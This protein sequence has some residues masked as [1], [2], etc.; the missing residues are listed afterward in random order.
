MTHA[1]D[2]AG[3]LETAISALLGAPVE[4]RDDDERTADEAEIARLGAELLEEPDAA[5]T[6]GDVFDA[7]VGPDPHGRE[8]RAAVLDASWSGIGLGVD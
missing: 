8:E 7:V 2:H 5:D 6:I 3:S 1:P 4:A